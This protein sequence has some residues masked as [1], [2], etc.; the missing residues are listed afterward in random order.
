MIGGYSVV[1]AELNRIFAPQP[2]VSRQQVDRWSR[3]GTRNHDGQ[4]PPGPDVKH[5]D[6]PRTQPRYE[7]D[8]AAWV[9]WFRAGVPGPRGKGWRMWVEQE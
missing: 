6:P 1:A 9:T 3:R 2:P 5:P 7:F 8:T 4:P